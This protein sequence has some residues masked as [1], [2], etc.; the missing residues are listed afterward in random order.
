MKLI[1][2]NV[3]YSNDLTNLKVLGKIKIKG[4]MRSM[5]IVVVCITG[6]IVAGTE[7]RAAATNRDT[8]YEGVPLTLVNDTR[9]EV[10]LFLHADG[11]GSS[12]TSFAY[13]PP[14]TERTLAGSY[15]RGWRASM[16][17]NLPVNINQV[18][19]TGNKLYTTRLTTE[20][21]EQQCEKEHAKALTL[22]REGTRVS[23]YIR[24]DESQ[25]YEEVLF[26]GALKIFSEVGE[27]APELG[28]QVAKQFTT[29]KDLL[30]KLAPELAAKLE[31]LDGASGGKLITEIVEVMTEEG[32]K[33]N[34]ATALANKHGIPPEIMTAIS[35]SVK[36][37]TERN[38]KDEFFKFLKRAGSTDSDEVINKKANEFY[39]IVK[40]S[41]GDVVNLE[42]LLK[43]IC[44]V[45]AAPEKVRRFMATLIALV[46]IGANQEMIPIDRV[47]QSVSTT[48]SNASQ[49]L[50]EY[51]EAATLDEQK[52]IRLALCPQNYQPQEPTWESGKSQI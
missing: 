41:N 30:V 29:K 39:L 21:T 23:W 38:F 46:T 12:H 17:L 48:R 18:V 49:T 10:V 47:A 45:R 9:E 52:A 27:V 36:E 33:G 13:M 3:S 42:K 14:C 24:K 37:Q 22:A 19:T 43:D 15:S 40:E 31:K 11:E 25:G 44:G 20:A 34:K 1:S 2:H 32:S 51:Y 50:R 5:A 8:D 16:N 6:G 4:L 35:L 28:S 7:A 26:G